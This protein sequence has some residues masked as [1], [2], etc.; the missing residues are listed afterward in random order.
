MPHDFQVLLYNT[1]E[2]NT[3]LSKMSKF[4]HEHLGY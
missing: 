2:S 3:S 1:T 4:L